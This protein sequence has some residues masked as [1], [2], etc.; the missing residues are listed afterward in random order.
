MQPLRWAGALGHRLVA[1]SERRAAAKHKKARVYRCYEYADLPS[2]AQYKSSGRRRL[3]S[4]ER[5]FRYLFEHSETRLAAMQKKLVDEVTVALLLKFFGDDLVGNLRY[6]RKKYPIDKLNDTIGI[7]FPR[8]SGKTEGMAMLVAV[9]AVSQPH[10]NCV[11]F[12]LTAIQAKEFL[13]SVIKY[14]MVAR[15]ARTSGP[16]GRRSFLY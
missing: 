3:D 15:F 8:R 13:Q 14:L 6:L 2:M 9:V 7:L 4:F 12:N 1:R 10:G 16:S 11:L 5:A